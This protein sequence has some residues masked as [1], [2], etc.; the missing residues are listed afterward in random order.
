MPRDLSERTPATS[1]TKG[2]NASLGA[3]NLNTI[4]YNMNLSRISGNP[5]ISFAQY[6]K[7]LNHNLNSNQVQVSTLD[8]L[9]SLSKQN[10]D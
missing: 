4:L 2:Q 3:G 10:K 8:T 1:K 7:G 5:H 6:L 9:E